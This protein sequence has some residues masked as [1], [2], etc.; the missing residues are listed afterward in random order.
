MATTPEHINLSVVA[1]SAMALSI[2]ILFTDALREG[3][4]AIHSASTMRLAMLRI[5][6]TIFVVILMVMF[7]KK[8]NTILTT[9][10]DSS[11][12]IYPPTST[13]MADIH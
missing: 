2:A 3:T 4:L 7:S 9:S 5:I 8:H 10:R 13:V 11:S 6:I 12:P 1:Q